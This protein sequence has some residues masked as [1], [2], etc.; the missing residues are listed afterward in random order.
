M[1]DG[2]TN[3]ITELGIAAQPS[4]QNLKVTGSYSCPLLHKKAGKA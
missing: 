1:K 3:R 2:L 4:R